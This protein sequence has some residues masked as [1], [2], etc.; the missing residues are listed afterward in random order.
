MQSIQSDNLPF[1]VDMP[2]RVVYA[3]AVSHENMETTLK[4]LQLQIQVLSSAYEKI[5]FKLQTQENR[6]KHYLEITK[7][8]CTVQQKDLDN[9]GKI[10]KVLIKLFKYILKHRNQIRNNYP[11]IKKMNTI[12]ENFIQDK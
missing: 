8:Y 6:Y 10:K 11:Q 5:L 9:F 12:I 2:N 3:H 4:L 1:Q 7:H